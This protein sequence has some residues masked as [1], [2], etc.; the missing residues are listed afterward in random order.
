MKTSLAEIVDGRLVLPEGALAL[1]P[2]GMPLRVIT[3]TE[4][5]TVCVYAK[6][7]MTPLSPDS[8]AFLDALGE[9]SADST[10]DKYFA[11]VTEEASWRSRRTSSCP[12]S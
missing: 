5:K 9:L 11:P 1:L 7:P 8:A 3:D 2:A 10:D 12:T 4:R 6:D